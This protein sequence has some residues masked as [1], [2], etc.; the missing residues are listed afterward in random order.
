MKSFQNSLRSETILTIYC[1]NNFWDKNSAKLKARKQ[2]LC[3][4]SLKET[5]CSIEHF[6]HLKKEKIYSASEEY[7]FSTRS[8]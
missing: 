2:L 8:I 4:L 1:P 7:S 6:F 5:G 3:M